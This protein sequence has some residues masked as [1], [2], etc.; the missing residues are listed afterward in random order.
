MNNAS[1]YKLFPAH[2]RI[3]FLGLSL[4]CFIF[5]SHCCVAEFSPA[6]DSTSYD[7][8]LKAGKATYDR[9]CESCHGVNAEGNGRFAH[10]LT[11]KPADLTIISARN[12]GIFPLAKMYQ[13]IDGTD[14]FLAH[15]SRE[16]PIWGERF[17]LNNWGEGNWTRGYTEH[18]IR[19]ARGRILELLMYLDSI[20]K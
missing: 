17:D 6:D 4:A 12:N 5:Y 3:T 16:M 10:N 8:T 13:V 1:I 19:I 14:N 9:Y 18:S 2:N 7:H 20:Q 11:T 15:G